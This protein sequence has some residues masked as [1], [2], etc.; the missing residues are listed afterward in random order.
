MH[1]NLLCVLYL[2]HHQ[3]RVFEVLDNADV[4][5]AQLNTDGTGRLLVNVSFCVIF[6]ICQMSI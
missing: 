4:V 6:V 1:L 5:L 2:L 3:D